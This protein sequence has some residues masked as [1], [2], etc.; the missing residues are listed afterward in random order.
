MHGKALNVWSCQPS[1]DVSASNFVHLDH[2]LY[3]AGV[4]RPSDINC[5]TVPV[6]NVFLPVRATQRA[7]GHGYQHCGGT[8]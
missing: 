2:V 5:V 8:R 4:C 6:G 1:T 7:D 3:S